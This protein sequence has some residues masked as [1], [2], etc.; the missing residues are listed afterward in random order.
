MLVEATQFYAFVAT[1][2][3]TPKRH[4]FKKQEEQKVKN[5]YNV[6]YV[7]VICDESEVEEKILQEMRDRYLNSLKMAEEGHYTVTEYYKEIPPGL[8]PDFPDGKKYDLKIRYFKDMRMEEVI[9][10]LSAEMFFKLC[11]ELGYSMIERKDT[12]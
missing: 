6:R 10:K 3:G 1:Y 11:D 5:F 12:K 7:T 8:F 4:I 2:K 9:K